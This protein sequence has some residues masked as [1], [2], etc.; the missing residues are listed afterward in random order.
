MAKRRRKATSTR[1]RSRKSSLTL[2]VK[3]S[4]MR[5]IW[6]VMYLGLGF[7]TFLSLSN[8]FGL[9]GE[10]WVSVLKPILGWGIVALPYMFFGAALMLF[11][12]KELA[13]PLSRILGIFFMT[14]S[15][16][17]IFHLS[18]PMDQIYLAATQGLYGGYV[19]FV[20]NFLLRQMLNVGQLGA[21]AIFV[22]LFVVS[23]LLTF[24]ISLQKVFAF[25]NPQIRFVRKRGAKATRGDQEEGDED[26][27]E[28]SAENEEG[29]EDM[30]RLFDEGEEGD[31]QP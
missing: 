11:L 28:D 1:R 23:L 20:T 9:A 8:N 22:T 6:A 4:V 17:S 30:E 12:A 16:L 21:G 18:V 2:E 26:D 27:I 3:S 7:I 19:G 25:F 10:V 31:P 29:D 14:V 24:E 15:V 5:E 13:F